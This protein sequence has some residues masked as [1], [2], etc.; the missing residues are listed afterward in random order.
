MWEMSAIIVPPQLSISDTFYA[1]H[2]EQFREETVKPRSHEAIAVGAQL[3]AGLVYQ[4]MTDDGFREEVY[5]SY[6]EQLEKKRG[7]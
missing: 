6:T 3:I 4:T 5:H 7:T 2:T 1:L